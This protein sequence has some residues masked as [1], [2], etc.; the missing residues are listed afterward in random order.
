VTAAEFSLVVLFVAGAL[1]GLLDLDFVV[2]ELLNSVRDRGFASCQGK[3][4]LSRDGT[5]CAASRGPF[6]LM[7]R[8]DQN[9]ARGRHFAAVGSSVRERVY[10]KDTVH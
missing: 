6:Y 10:A 3:S 5:A 9:F 4:S 1:A 7:R 8:E 2:G